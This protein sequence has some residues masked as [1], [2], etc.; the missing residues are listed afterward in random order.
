MINKIKG[1]VVASVLL[2][3][4]F[5]QDYNYEAKISSEK[6]QEDFSILTTSLTENHP[7]LY[8]FT[9]KAQFDS[10][11]NVY[12]KSLTDSLTE[13][14]FNVFT[15]KFLKVIGC[16]HT[17]SVP[18]PN[19]YKEV[20]GKA[21]Q[22]PI[23]VFVYKEELY[24]RDI[25]G[26]TESYDHL[27]GARVVSI[28][29]NASSYIMKEMK[30]II[31]QDGTGEVMVVRNIERL[32][33]TYYAF[34]FGMSDDYSFELE[35]EGEVFKV[36]IKANSA[37][38]YQVVR[39]AEINELLKGTK[40]TF[41]TIGDSNEVA[42]LRL[43]SFPRKGYKKY[44]RQVFKLLE[45]MG[46]VPLILDLRGNSGGYFPNS[47]RLLCYL[48]PDKFTMDFSKPQECTKKNEHL[49]L[50]FPSKMT[51]FAFS[52]IPDQDKSDPDRN[53]QVKFKP[54][55]RNHFDGKL[56]V[57]TDGW[58]F[59]TSSF[60]ASKLK[61]SIGAVTVGEETGGGE[62]GFNAV[63]TWKLILPN[64]GVHV[65]IPMYHVDV[66]K[67]QEEMGRGVVPT[68]PVVYNWNEKMGGI[69]LETKKILEELRLN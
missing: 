15:R 12:E 43:R 55:K 67:E 31:G 23:H 20:R 40:A 58:T 51:R 45:E 36:L 64:S 61:N 14:E 7:G 39:S 3:K 63:L 11:T 2:S 65:S 66:Q 46:D 69:D 6:L 29:G 4:C 34:L 54:I 37:K 44:Y 68:I 47:N 28:N 59:S 41:G 22:V 5:A 42:I 18:S 26:D 10:L 32:F 52:T 35:S 60:V 9:P 57:I 16:G 25:F 13:E 48:M 53:Y 21:K 50:S 27:L 17:T 8:V 56:Y 1:L 19:W 62:V 38:R 49:E 24:I 33:Q 30:S